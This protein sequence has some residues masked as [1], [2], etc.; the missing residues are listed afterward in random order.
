MQG[1][2]DGKIV[3]GNYRILK[4]GTRF[5]FKNNPC[6]YCLFLTNG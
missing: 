3:V 6:I 2:I 4:E 1:M 5:I